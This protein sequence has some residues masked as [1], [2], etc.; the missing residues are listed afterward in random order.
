MEAR[1][2]STAKAAFAIGAI[3]TWAAVILQLYLIL[4]NRTTSVV[5]TLMRFFTF[6][7][8]LSNTLAA[9]CFTSLLISGG[10][11]L[12]VFFSKPVVIS[13]VTVYILIVCLVY[14]V[15]LR[16]LWHPEG[17]QK[18]VDELLHSVN[19]VF[20]LLCWLFFVPKHALQWK[21]IFSWM[22]FPLCYLGVILF[23]GSV[24][25][26]Y[27]YPFVDVVKLGYQKVFLNCGM[28]L[29]VFLVFSFIVI[30]IGK[31]VGK[32]STITA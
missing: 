32:T 9:I 21:N 7:T 19:P 16:P 13:A 26:Y 3:I 2:S 31:A 30:G 4:Y 18:I 22:I 15:V 10:V 14:Q 12:K 20:F 5:E 1:T 11:K 29:L 27:P 28:V 8:I 17:L 24:S 6:F 23:Q 25:N